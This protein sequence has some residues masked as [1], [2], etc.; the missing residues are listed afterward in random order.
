MKKLSQLVANSVDAYMEGN[1]DIALHINDLAINRAKRLNVPNQVK[2]TVHSNKG[3]TLLASGCFYAAQLQ[4]QLANTYKHT[5]EN[6]WSIFL[7]LASQGKFHEALP[8][9]HARYGKT[10][11]ASTR[12][13]FPDNLPIPQVTEYDSIVGCNVLILNE[14]GL[15]DEILFFSAVQKLA[16]QLGNVTLQCYPEAKRLFE[17]NRPDNVTITTDKVM[18]EAFVKQHD[19]WIATGDLWAIA[20]QF[21]L[22]YTCYLNVKPEETSPPFGTGFCW[23]ANA[24][25]PNAKLR[26]VEVEQLRQFP[27]FAWSL[28]KDDYDCPD[29]MTSF[30][31]DVKDLYDT[32]CLIKGMEQVVSCDTSIVHLAGALN[33]PTTLVINKHH[34]WRWRA[35]D[36]QGYSLFY[37]SIKVRQL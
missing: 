18:T 28:Q 33:I 26:S 4:F 15:G 11:N 6:D 34:D 31:T 8:Y 21:S 2:E 30:P 19:C 32:A 37:P 23:R 9:H 14:Q 22:D 16:G 1:F 36:D 3:F 10:R 7:C 27:G 24:S 20:S 13:I 12:V 5:D 25:S 29:W 17:T 35:L